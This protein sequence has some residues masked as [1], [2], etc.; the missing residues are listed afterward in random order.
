MEGNKKIRGKIRVEMTVKVER[1]KK[2]N[3]GKNYK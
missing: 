3:S 2:D 1:E